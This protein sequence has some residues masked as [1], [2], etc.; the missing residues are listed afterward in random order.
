M[1]VQTRVA[2]FGL[3]KQTAKGAGASS[4]ATFGLGTL[5]GSLLVIDVDQTP[6][7]ITYSA[8]RRVSPDENRMGIN[9]GA[10]L[11]TRAYPRSIGL[12]LYGALGAI[13]STPGAPNLHVITPGLTLPYL[14]I[15]TKLG[16]NYAKVID[17][18]VDELKISWDE[19]APLE[20]EATFMGGMAS[21]NQ[22]A[23]TQTNDESAQAKFVPPGGTFK[24]HGS[25]G[26]PATAKITGG[27]IT[28][29]NNS[30]VIPLS[31]SQTPDD[32]FEGEQEFPVSLKLMPDD[33][34]E[35]SRAITG[36]DAGTSVASSPVYGSFEV[37]FVI[38]ASNDLMLAASRVA[39][40]PEYPE[41][42][43][44][45]GPAELVMEGRAKQPAAGEA[46]TATLHNAIAAY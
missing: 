31:A 19:R 34:T 33:L 43:P 13:A 3:S 15:F 41:A 10:S 40:S 1:P 22:S 20:V 25:S 46:F 29:S 26:T 21:L 38:D 17:N 24:L 5:G 37:K 28:I 8:D 35:W 32:V 23:W 12:L 9:P 18:K 2:F 16:A 44:G 42:D 4:P 6:D 11:K 45:G 30:Q 14:T 36:A 39:Y 27:E 7:E